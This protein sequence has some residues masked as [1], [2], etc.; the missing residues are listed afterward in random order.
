MYSCDEE[1]F[2]EVAHRAA[3]SGKRRVVI[4]VNIVAILQ[5]GID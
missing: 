2:F 4:N 5:K 3:W 1:G